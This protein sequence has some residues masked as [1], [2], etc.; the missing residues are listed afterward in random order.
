MDILGISFEKFLKV[1]INCRETRSDKMLVQI[2]RPKF[3]L[4]ALVLLVSWG[5]QVEVSASPVPDDPTVSVSNF[6]ERTKNTFSTDQNTKEKLTT[7][8][9]VLI[10]V[11][12]FLVFMF[13][14]CCIGYC[15]CECVKELICCLCCCCRN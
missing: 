11:G 4:V 8:E 5:K 13:L 10:G 15:L 9:V 14:L 1:N 12:A 2:L 7:T 3:L 6:I